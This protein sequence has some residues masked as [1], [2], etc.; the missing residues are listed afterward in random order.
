MNVKFYVRAL[1]CL[2]LTYLFSI[3]HLSAQTPQKDSPPDLVAALKVGDTLPPELW[4]LPLEVVNHPEGKKTITLNE[5]KDKLIILDF[6]AT[7]CAPCIKS[8]HKLDSLQKKFGKRL[9]VMPST[10]EAGDKALPAFKKRGWNLPSVVGNTI[11][12]KYFPH[13]SIPHQVWIK[14]GKVL[15]LAGPASST[16]D[17]IEKALA[18]RPFQVMMK[19]ESNVKFDKNKPLLVDGNGGGAEALLYQS[20]VSKEISYDGAGTVSRGN[21]LLIYNAAIQDLF[22]EAYRDTIMW[23]ARVNRVVSTLSDSLNEKVFWPKP[24][25]KTDYASQIHLKNWRKDNLY[26]Y[27]LILPKDIPRAQKHQ[28]VKTDLNRFFGNFLGINARIENRLTPCL[29]ITKLANKDIWVPENKEQR[30]FI[31]DEATHYIYD[32]KPFKNFVHDF[33]ERNKRSSLPIV[34]ETGYRGNISME[35]KGPL[36]DWAMVR[37]ELQRNGFDLI[38]EELNIDLLVFH[39]VNK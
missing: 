3:L 36:T 25:S 32:N 16:A 8:L 11:L 30:L 34:D 21:K 20:L 2:Y 38:E 7:W 14:E 13:T 10:Y 24:S 27:S 26:C 15:V 23:S 9:A 31:N 19:E 6:W 39:S 4:N 12:K 33:E 5:Y 35:F 17:N 18:S 1:L 29:V 37:K 22:W 28:I